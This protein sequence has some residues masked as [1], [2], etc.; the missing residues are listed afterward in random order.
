MPTKLD[1][2]PI[3]NAH[4]GLRVEINDADIST[5][6]RLNPDACAAANALC[7]MKDVEAAKVYRHCVYLKRNG[8]WQRFR[9]SSAL[10][11]ETIVFDRGGKFLP[12]EYDLLPVPISE[13]VPKSS[14]QRSPNAPKRKPSQPQ[15]HRAFIPGTRPTANGLR[16]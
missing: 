15:R 11:L 13:I 4:R 7:N 6:K 5:G 2:K 8:K 1:N 12:G 16:G 9:T 3:N 10:R 14:R